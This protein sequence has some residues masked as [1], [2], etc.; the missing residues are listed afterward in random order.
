MT[1]AGKLGTNICEVSGRSDQFWR[2]TG[3]DDE[4]LA[5]GQL[6]HPVAGCVRRVNGKLRAEKCKSRKAGREVPPVWKKVRPDVPLETLRY[7]EAKQH[8]PDLFL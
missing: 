6:M 7:N 5:L 8:E 1:G 3:P 2:L 4:G